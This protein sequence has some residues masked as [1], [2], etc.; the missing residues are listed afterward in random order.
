MMTQTAG[1]RIRRDG[2]LRR[3][4]P[5]ETPTEVPAEGFPIHLYDGCE[6]ELMAPFRFFGFKGRR[7]D[8]KSGYGF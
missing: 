8:G 5:I 2:C 7:K 1:M 3:R 4:D 6:K